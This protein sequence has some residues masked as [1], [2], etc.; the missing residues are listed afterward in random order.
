MQPQQFSSGEISAMTRLFSA[1]VVRD[2][3]QFGRSKLWTRLLYEVPLLNELKP[4]TLVRNIYDLVYKTLLKPPHRQE[5]IYKSALANKVLL[6]RHNLRT[7]TMLTEFRVNDR[8]ADVVILNG[9]S[10]AY[11]IKSE[12]DRLDRLSAQMDAYMQVFAISYVVTGENHVENV[13]RELPHEIGILKFNNRNGFMIV[14][15]AVENPGR[16]NVGVLFESLR[17]SEVRE[18][19]GVCDVRVPSVPNTL[20]RSVLREVFIKLNPTVV[21]NAM[22]STLRESRS[23]KRLHRF[24]MTLPESLRAAVITS[25][26]RAHSY[27]T[28]L[29]AMQSTLKNAR[30]W[31]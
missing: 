21:H 16:I 30:S 1:A 27:S 28:F 26:M 22:V 29:S 20:E 31:V 13:V 3:A 4:S 15:E 23:Q 11:E 25:N 2:F 5:Y 8:K 18:I 17:T 19:L 7:A 14:R 12:H 6:G 24:V 9:T 10:V